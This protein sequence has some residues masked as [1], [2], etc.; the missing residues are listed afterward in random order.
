MIAAAEEGEDL[1]ADGSRLG[2][3][4]ID[5]AVAADQ[6]DEGARAGEVRFEPAHIERNEVHGDASDER[7]WL[8]GNDRAAAIA[9]RAQPSIRVTDRHGRDAAR[10]VQA[11]GRTI[12]NG[13]PPVN[14]TGLDDSSF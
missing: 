2:G 9:E 11:M 4:I 1:V 5:R 8:A 3:D 10:P 14:V 6:L 12:A 7:N 13:I